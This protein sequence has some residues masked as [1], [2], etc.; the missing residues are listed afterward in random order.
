MYTSGWNISKWHLLPSL[1]KQGDE[2][3]YKFQFTQTNIISS[4]SGKGGPYL[5][6]S[7]QHL[8]VFTKL[9]KP[10]VGFL[11][12]DVIRFIIYLD[13]IL[14]L[15]KF[16]AHLHLSQESRADG[17]PQSL[18]DKRQGALCA[19][20]H[21]MGGKMINFTL[22]WPVQLAHSVQL[23]GVVYCSGALAIGCLI[24]CCLCQVTWQQARIVL[25]TPWWNTQPWFPVALGML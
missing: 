22:W 21:Y 17:G 4:F 14:I 12:H 2:V 5:L 11:C 23:S 9:L 7:Q 10:V 25:I 24:N 19:L 18:P 8:G 13:D 1:I 6:V 16:S 3:G 20:F 15:Q